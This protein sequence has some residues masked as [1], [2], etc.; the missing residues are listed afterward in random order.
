MKLCIGYG[1]TKDKC[2]HVV[3]INSKYWCDSCDKKVAVTKQL[4]D[5]VRSFKDNDN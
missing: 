3:G 4:E 2:S 1:K 5:I